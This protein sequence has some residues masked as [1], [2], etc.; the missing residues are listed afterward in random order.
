MPAIAVTDFNYMG[1]AVDLHN[2]FLSS[3]S[4]AIIGTEFIVSL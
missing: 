3:K 1:E 4:K 2:E